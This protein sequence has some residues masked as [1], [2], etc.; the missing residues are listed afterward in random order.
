[1]DF[2]KFQVKKFCYFFLTYFSSH[3]SGRSSEIVW[4]SGDADVIWIFGGKSS[5]GIFADLWQLDLQTL[6]W[7]WISGPSAAY[8]TGIYGTKYQL[9]NGNPGSRHFSFSWIQGNSTLYLFGGEGL[10]NT[11][12][13][14][15]LNDMWV[16]D[17]QNVSF[18]PVTTS[19]A[20]GSSTTTSSTVFNVNK[21]SIYNR[22]L[23]HLLLELLAERLERL[24]L[25]LL[26][27]LLALVQRLI[28]VLQV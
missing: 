21:A 12:K 23:H 15:Q 20:A 17:F 3:F 11:S 22:G 7:A 6:S 9:S 14:G 19:T 1:M 27:R 13:Q 24:V 25:H 5:Q 18:V 16:Y 2:E 28:V 4:R 10:D 26:P 8:Q